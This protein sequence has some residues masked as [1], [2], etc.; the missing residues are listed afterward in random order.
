[1]F[2][3]VGR[4]TIQKDIPNSYDEI[5]PF[6]SFVN[7][8]G[9]WKPDH[10]TPEKKIA[11]II[12][13]RARQEN[14]LVLLRHLN[15]ILKRQQLHYQIFVVD[16]V[17]KF[18]FNK[19]KL[20]NIGYK[21]AKK[22][23]ESFNCFIFHDADFLAANDKNRYDCPT[24]PLHMSPICEKFEYKKHSDGYFG[25]VIAVNTKDFEGRSPFIRNIL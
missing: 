12:P 13:Y 19:G 1:M 21:I 5:E 14:L 24:S 4:I 8:G 18:P 2:I 11:I 23:N 3:S 15:P 22:L 6:I 20:L 9:W 17:D 25:G 10:C 16:Q 7:H